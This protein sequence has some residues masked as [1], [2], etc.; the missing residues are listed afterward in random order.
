[1]QATLWDGATQVG[2]A[3]FIGSSY[4]AIATLLQPLYIPTNADKILTVRADLQRIGVAD[5]GRSGDIVKI[6]F[7]DTYHPE[8]TLAIGVMTGSDVPVSGSTEVAG[9]RIFKSFPTFALDYLPGTGVADGRLMRFKITASPAGTVSLAKFTLAFAIFS[10]TVT[11][12]NIFAYT[13]SLYSQPISGVGPGGK[14]Q[15][16]D[17]C[18]SPCFPPNTAMGIYP[19]TVTGIRTVLYIPWPFL[20]H[21][22]LPRLYR[23][24]NLSHRN[25]PLI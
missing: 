25:F 9:V 18:P 7:D 21:H 16:T 11:S 17:L 23:C 8:L 3:I 14:L 4:W 10:A 24:G 15:S 12:A 5:P 6:D 2:T 20:K 22:W 13:D 19:E 1:M